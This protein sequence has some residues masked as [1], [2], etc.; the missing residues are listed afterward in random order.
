[1]ILYLNLVQQATNIDLSHL[2]TEQQENFQIILTQLNSSRY[3][4]MVFISQSIKTLGIFRFRTSKIVI[5][6]YIHQ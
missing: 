6:K 1:M 5:K 4:W 3:V 2:T